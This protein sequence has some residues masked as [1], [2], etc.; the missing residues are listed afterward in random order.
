MIFKGS[1]SSLTDLLQ[2]LESSLE[3]PLRMSHSHRCDRAIEFGVDEVLQIAG[4]NADITSQA[5][6]ILP[7]Q[8]A[9]GTHGS[10]WT[11]P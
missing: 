11:G 7:E 5:R 6:D 4:L 10:L 3:I 2:L 1:G 8:R 9:M